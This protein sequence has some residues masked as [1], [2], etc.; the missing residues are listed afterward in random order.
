MRDLGL[1]RLLALLEVF[2]FALEMCDL[3]QS[4]RR[5]LGAALRPR[6]MSFGFLGK[7]LDLRRVLPVPELRLGL[8]S[9]ARGVDVA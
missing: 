8:Q 1:E 7:L 4:R 2:N 9:D 5:L 3:G 6:F